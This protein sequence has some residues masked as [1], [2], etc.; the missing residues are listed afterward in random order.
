MLLVCDVVRVTNHSPLRLHPHCLN[1]QVAKERAEELKIAEELE[2]ESTTLLSTV[3]SPFFFF[4]VWNKDIVHTH[5]LTAIA[6]FLLGCN[7]V[8]P[9]VR[10]VTSHSMYNTSITRSTTEI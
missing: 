5:M 1:T 7:C 2:G 4:L 9:C 8:R 3:F 10:V 6:F